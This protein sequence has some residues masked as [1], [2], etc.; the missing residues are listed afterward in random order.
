M[1]LKDVSVAVK[2]FLKS[3][4]PQAIAISGEWG[5]GKTYFW[6]EVIKEASNAG[7]FKKYSYVSLFGINNLVDL[8]ATLFDNALSAEDVRDGTSSSTWVKNAKEAFDAIDAYRLEDSKKPLLWLTKWIWKIF[9]PLLPALSAWGGVAKSLSFMAVKNYVICLDDVE[10]KGAGLTLKEVL[11]LISLLKEQ[12]GCRVAVIFNDDV[13]DEKDDFKTS[14]EKVFDAEI[15]FS[16][17]A[18]E[19]AKLVFDDQWEHS[20]EVI[21]KVVRLGVKNIRVLQR[22]RRVIET[23][24]PY[25]KG[26]DMAL[27]KQLIHSSILLTWCYSS[28]GKDVPLYEIVKNVSMSTWRK[29]DEM[30]DEQKVAEKVLSGYEYRTSDAFDLSICQFLEDGFVEEDSFIGVVGSSQEKALQNNHSGSFTDAWMMFFNTFDDNEDAL[31]DVLRERFLSGSK[32]INIGDAMATVKL[33]RDLE[34]ED[35]ADE[36]MGHWIEMAKQSN[37]G[38]LKITELHHQLFGD[39]VDEKFKEAINSSH[40]QDTALPTLGDT[41]RHMTESNGFSPDQIE[42]LA[43]AS[44]D[45]YYHFFKSIKADAYLSAYVK[46]CVQ[47]SKLNDAEGRYLRIYENSYN[48]LQKISGENRLNKMRISRYLSRVNA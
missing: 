24:L 14:K 37:K 40:R 23:L 42:F 31:V 43:R 25:V 46:T 15:V 44:S 39:N 16:P 4:Q 29:R 13:L 34:R 21:D 5:S 26:K 38:L 30:S 10:R 45:D 32:W 33:M 48:A 6:G 20:H 8:K 17:S 18:K 11:G 19:C 41:I 47:F 22:I 7:A 27:T 1:S 9:S 35:I 3:D 12:K 36:L 28:R 2:N